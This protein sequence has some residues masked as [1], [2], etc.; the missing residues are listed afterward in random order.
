MLDLGTLPGGT[1][2]EAMAV[3]TNGQILGKATFLLPP[4]ALSKAMPCY[5]LPIVGYVSAENGAIAMTQRA[6][7]VA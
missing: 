5:G 6:R 1:N 2:S 4:P 7:I 3:N